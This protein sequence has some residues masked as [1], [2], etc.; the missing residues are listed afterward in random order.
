MHRIRYNPTPTVFLFT[1][2]QKLSTTPSLLEALFMCHQKQTLH[3]VTIDK[4]HLFAQHGRLFRESLRVLT[5]IFFVV[6]FR[7][8]CW[9]PLFL[10]MAATMA[11]N[12]IPSFSML[13][14][15]NLSLPQ[16]QMWSQWHNF[17]QRDITMNFKVVDYMAQAYPILINHLRENPNS[18]AFI[19]VNFRSECHTASCKIENIIIE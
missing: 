17:W 4:A 10:A 18:S 7:A 19:L 6:I 13:T 11:L 2:P 16:H 1:S 15:I 12:L 14:N 5:T 8:G 3:L 9:H